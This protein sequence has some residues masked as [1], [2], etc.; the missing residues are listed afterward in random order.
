M[1]IAD[2]TRKILWGRSGNRCA[3]CRLELIASATPLDD[4]A[5]VGDECH[6]VSSQE[7]GPRYDASFPATAIDSY[8]N[9][10]LLCKVHH[11]LV[12][13]Q[14]DTYG[15]EV[16]KLIKKNH[17]KWVAEKLSN[18][19]EGPAPVRIRRIKKNIPAF[20]LRIED[21]RSLADVVGDSQAYQFEHDE[22][23]TEEERDLVAS[24]LQSAEDWGDLSPELEAGQRVHATYDFSLALRELDA[25]GFWVFGASEVRRLEGGIGAPTAFKVA[26]I[27]VLRKTNPKILSLSDLKA[28]M[29]DSLGD[30]GSSAENAYAVPREGHHGENPA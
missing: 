24:F 9:L 28:S 13:D 10:L 14:A 29:S 18:T 19:V 30:S 27:S 21:G 5:V 3:M 23:A 22:L 15:V 25:A 26:I 4:E 17:E 6:I 16:L 2:K 1:T 20:L 8:D 7:S 12:D 11:K